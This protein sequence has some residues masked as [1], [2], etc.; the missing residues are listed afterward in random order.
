MR[1]FCCGLFIIVIF[2][3]TD[4]SQLHAQEGGSEIGRFVDKT[5]VIS[6]GAARQTMASAF[7][8]PSAIAIPSRLLSSNRGLITGTART[9]R[10]INI[11]GN[12][13]GLFTAAPTVSADPVKRL[14]SAISTSTVSTTR[15]A[16]RCWPS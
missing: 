15:W 8:P 10:P 2:L 11:A 6:L 13:A 5:H 7:V 14:R 12:H 16:P 1:G 9:L 4:I 3:T